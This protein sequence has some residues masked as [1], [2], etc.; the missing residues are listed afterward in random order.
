MKWPH[1]HYARGKRVRVV[2]RDGTRVVGKFVERRA[3]FVVLDTARIHVR[4]IKGM[5]FYQRKY[6]IPND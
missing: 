2:L 3:R 1:T 6:E 4:Q 5:G